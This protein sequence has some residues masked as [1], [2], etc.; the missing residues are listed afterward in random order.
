MAG[1]ESGTFAARR[2]IIDTMKKPDIFDLALITGAD[3]M[4]G[5]YIDSGIRTNHRSLDVTNLAEVMKVCMHHK[6]KLVIHLAAETDVDYCEHDIT[7]AYQV[8]AIG[9]Y[10]MA[11]AAK[12]V[13][14]KLVYIST[15]GVFDGTK[16]EPYTEE[17]I[18]AP[19]HV[20]GHSKYLGELAVQGMLDDYLILRV[21][22]VFG[23]GPS[24][25][26][27]FIAK[28]LQ[29]VDQ[30]VIKVIGGK[31]GSPTYG[32]DLVVGIKRLVKEGKSGL[33]HMGNAGSPTRADTVKE[34][35]R[36][37]ASRAK[38]EEVDPSFFGAANASRPN[39]ESM[40]SMVPYMRPWQE[41]LEEYIH[42]E[43]HL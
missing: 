39:N 30:P 18:P 38:V 32:K 1:A 13:G 37:T 16:V 3:G 28:I 2:E 27:K 42:E 35:V 24:K 31:R 41:A 34:I 23:G 12:A 22:W 7:H 36:I 29:Q 25:D 6:P 11:T 17:D 26:Q 10:N 19:S 21:C 8:N 33:Y 14:A 9:T 15:S 20:Y 5:S 4:I 43:W 40:V